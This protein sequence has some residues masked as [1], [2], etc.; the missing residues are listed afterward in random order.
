[1]EG[2]LSTPEQGIALVRGG[3]YTQTG[4]YTDALRVN[5]RVGR[6]IMNSEWRREAAERSCSVEFHKRLWP[7]WSEA[8][9][10]AVAR[11]RAEKDPVKLSE[12]FGVILDSRYADLMEFDPASTTSW[13]DAGEIQNDV[14]KDKFGETFQISVV[15]GRIGRARHSSIDP[16]QAL[17]RQIELIDKLMVYQDQ[18]SPGDPIASLLRP[19]L[20][21]AR[22]SSTIERIERTP[23]SSDDEIRKVVEKT[24][25]FELIRAYNDMAPKLWKAPWNALSTASRLLMRHHYPDFWE[26]L[27]KAGMTLEEAKKLKS[28]DGDFADFEA[29]LSEQED[30]RAA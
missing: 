9:D 3:H 14:K 30:N 8:S 6:G 11:I 12:M 20:I 28:W 10:R 16:I 26:R 1:M 29:W 18:R 19:K 17:S 7:C 4:L 2:I 25:F 13:Q 27:Q 24:A 23:G 15:Y 5:E 22:I 21:I